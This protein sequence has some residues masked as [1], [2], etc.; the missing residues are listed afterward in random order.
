M[1][2]KILYWAS[3][4]PSGIYQCAN[5]R[6]TWC[7]QS[8]LAPI[9]LHKTDTASDLLLIKQHYKLIQKACRESSY[10]INLIT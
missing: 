1:L 9:G 10:K 4:A 8:E 2:Y 3:G 5:C 6:P 7:G